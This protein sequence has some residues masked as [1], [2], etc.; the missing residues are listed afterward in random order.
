MTG[1]WM[2]GDGW[3]RR[4]WLGAAGLAIASSAFSRGSVFADQ[5]PVLSRRMRE[6]IGLQR[7]GFVFDRDYS[8]LDEFVVGYNDGTEY[9]LG[10]KLC[11]NGVLLDLQ[12]LDDGAVRVLA[13]RTNWEL[14]GNRLLHRTPNARITTELA[15]NL[16]RTL[17]NE[18]GVSTPGHSPAATDRFCL[19]GRPCRSVPSAPRADA[20]CRC[21]IRA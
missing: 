12:W 13:Q 17:E 18:L 2:N 7:D 3:T 10:L 21:R 4:A 20:R 6:Y 5:V 19:P 16:M 8:T 15:Q 14:V 11:D 9:P 1:D